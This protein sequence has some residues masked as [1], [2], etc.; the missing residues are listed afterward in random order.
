ML[1]CMDNIMREY[2]KKC[3]AHKVNKHGCMWW[4]VSSSVLLFCLCIRMADM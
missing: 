3:T 2:Y 4:Y 1:D